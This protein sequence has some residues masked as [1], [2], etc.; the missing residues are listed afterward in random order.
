MTQYR[1]IVPKEW[2]RWGK[3][4]VLHGEK[5]NGTSPDFLSGLAEGNSRPFFRLVKDYGPRGLALMLADEEILGHVEKC[6][7]ESILGDE[8]RR[9]NL[10]KIGEELARVGKRGRKKELLPEEIREKG[11]TRKQTYDA[12]VDYALEKIDQI[13]ESEYGS[14]FRK[15]PRKYS[16]GAS[17]R[18][19]REQIQENVLA[20]FLNSADAAE[21][22]AADKKRDEQKRE[23]SQDIR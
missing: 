21:R 18:K 16:S 22:K 11:R 19:L 4:F 3:D 23:S 1:E 10:K 14:A 15:D 7:V 12:R 17:A 6:W 13:T 20:R 2:Q 9:E 5:K 8:A